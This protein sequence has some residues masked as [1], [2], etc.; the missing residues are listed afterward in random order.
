VRASVRKLRPSILITIISFTITNITRGSVPFRPD[1][2]L[3]PQPPQPLPPPPE[4]P[5]PLRKD[6]PP[7]PSRDPFRRRD[8]I[9]PVDHLTVI[10]PFQFQLSY[11]PIIYSALIGLLYSSDPQ[12]LISISNE[13]N[14]I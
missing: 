13:L 1:L 7:I 10:H 6:R 9:E 4:N 11:R 8:L 14:P 5:A 3:S 2:P 12:C